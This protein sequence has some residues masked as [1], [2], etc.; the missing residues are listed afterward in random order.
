MS[1]PAADVTGLLNKLLDMPTDSEYTHLDILLDIIA[2]S[3]ALAPS[4]GKLGGCSHALKH[5]VHERLQRYKA[6]VEAKLRQKLKSTNWGRAC[7][8]STTSLRMRDIGDNGA[9]LLARWACV[10]GS[11]HN[12]KSLSLSRNQIGDDGVRFLAG[13]IASGSL[14]NLQYLYLEDN[15]IGDAGMASLAGA[16]ASGS[17]GKLES[18]WLESNPIGDPGMTALA[19]A[20]ASGSLPNLKELIVGTKHEHHPQLVAACKPRKIPIM[21]LRDPY[22]GVEGW[23][24]GSLRE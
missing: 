22:H 11:L 15:L 17:L 8:A 14:E 21:P 24:L 16:I 20:I 10:S 5:Q 23:R 13:A 6:E 3:P 7:L 19:G 12:L 4:L 18:L 2:G 9:A 1:E